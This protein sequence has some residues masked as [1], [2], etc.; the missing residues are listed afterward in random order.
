MSLNL[1]EK[2]EEKKPV[3]FEIFPWGRTEGL[4][5]KYGMILFYTGIWNSLNVEC[6]IPPF[7]KK[8]DKGVLLYIHLNLAI[9]LLIALV[10]FV[11]GIQSVTSV[12]VS[13]CAY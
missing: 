2:F 9:A 4:G 1:K 10:V 12:P 11:A 7:R 8:L 3:F 5:M 6:S 13:M